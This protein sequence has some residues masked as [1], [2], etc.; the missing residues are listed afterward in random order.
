MRQITTWPSRSNVLSLAVFAA[1][2][3]SPG[4]VLMVLIFV[5]DIVL[6]GS[7]NAVFSGFLPPAGGQQA[8]SL[9]AFPL[10]LPAAGVLGVIE[11]LFGFVIV[12][13]AARAFSW[14]EGSWST[15]SVSLLT[16]RLGPTLLWTIVASIILGIAGSIGFLLLVIPGIY[17]TVNFMFVM[18]AI[19]VEDKDVITALRRS[20]SLAKGHRWRL[21][22]IF[23]IFGAV[24]GGSTAL[25]NAVG[26]FRPST[27]QVVKLALTS[28]LAT[29]G[30]GVIAD[31]YVQLRDEDS[32]VEPLAAA[33]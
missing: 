15:L 20:W 10:S 11:L 1:P 8:H 21:F 6:M 23:I 2:R 28:I 31:A 26:M 9:F 14:N 33:D 22:A 24:I 5:Y 4:A 3:H 19:A 30:Y 13:A 12:I 29:L 18:F 27:G 25:V 16:R 32:T 7:M 17:L